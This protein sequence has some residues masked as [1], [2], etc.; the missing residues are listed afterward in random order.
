[1]VRDEASEVAKREPRARGTSLWL[2]PEPVAAEALGRLITTL[3]RRLGTPSFEPHVTLLSGLTRPAEEVVRKAEGVASGIDGPLLLSPGPP[4]G[5]DEPF[6]CL[7]LPV[8]PTFNLLA[9]QAL[10][11]ATIGVDTEGPFEPH[12]SLVYGRL[13]SA[14]RS[15]LAREVAAELPGRTRFDTL[16][17]VRTTG[18][19]PEWRRIGRF[20]LGGP[21]AGRDHEPD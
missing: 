3:A 17:V 2:V 7:Y 8:G 16:D 15:A 9:L 18:P 6:Q 12:L 21:S 14:Q 19:V 1:M 10:A 5:R 20:H 13:D 4:E 11:R